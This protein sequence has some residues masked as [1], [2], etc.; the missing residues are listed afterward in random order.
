MQDLTLVHFLVH[1]T[2]VHLFSCAAVAHRSNGVTEEFRINHVHAI[3]APVPLW[4]LRMRSGH[5][6]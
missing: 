3:S 1:L 2:L 4:V 5:A 6:L